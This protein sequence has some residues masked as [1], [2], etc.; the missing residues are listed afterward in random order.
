MKRKWQVLTLNRVRA[1]KSFFV[2]NPNFFHAPIVAEA[3][4]FGAT[5]TLAYV[6]Y[7]TRKLADPKRRLP[8]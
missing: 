8:V 7:A 3:W 6:T 2:L 1:S 5:R 4:R